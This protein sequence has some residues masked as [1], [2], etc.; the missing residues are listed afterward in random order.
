LTAEDLRND[1]R[2]IFAGD[3]AEHK[4]CDD[5]G[6]VHARACPRIASLHVKIG[7]EGDTK[8]VI[9]ER[10]VTYWPPGQ[11]EKD[12]IFWDDVNEPDGT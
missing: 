12:I 6:G 1:A 2:A 4:A 5:C 7:T 11:W 10:H 8:G 3:D 9:I